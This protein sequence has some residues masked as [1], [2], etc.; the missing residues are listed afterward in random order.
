MKPPLPVKIPCPFLF[1]FSCV[2]LLSALSASARA[3]ATKPHPLWGNT[4][5]GNSAEP[6]TLGAFHSGS[7]SGYLMGELHDYV[8]SA[9][10]GW[11]FFDEETSNSV[12]EELELDLASADFDGDGDDDVVYVTVSPTTT[13]GQYQITIC[14]PGVT[15]DPISWGT[16]LDYE[17]GILCRPDEAF[18]SPSLLQTKWPW[19]LG[20]GL[21]QHPLEGEPS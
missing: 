21:L 12:V 17:A 19:S 6:I 15:S 1:L 9:F 3:E 10:G 5:L 8:S 2:F 20:S 7:S 11:D 4:I 13:A 18:E 14:V 16:Q